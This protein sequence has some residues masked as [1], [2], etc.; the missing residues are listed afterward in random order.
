MAR[1]GGYSRKNIIVTLLAI[2]EMTKLK[3]VKVTQPAQT[4][5]HEGGDIYVTPVLENLDD[6][7][8]MSIVDDY[9]T[10]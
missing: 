7:E 9:A 4:A 5:G 8:D 3:L 6:I 1:F 10:A 2:L